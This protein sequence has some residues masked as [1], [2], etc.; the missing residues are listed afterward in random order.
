[1]PNH[2]HRSGENYRQQGAG[3]LV[4]FVHSASPV[5]DQ[6]FDLEEHFSG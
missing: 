2:K 1:M 5:S 6:V 3:Q 4:N